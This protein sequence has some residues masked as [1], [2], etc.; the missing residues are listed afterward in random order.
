MHVG[1]LFSLVNAFQYLQVLVID[2]IG[3]YFTDIKSFTFNGVQ[4]SETTLKS[5]DSKW[6]IL[7]LE[8]LKQKKETFNIVYI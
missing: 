2:S 1:I 7:N 4:K 5:L 3:T 8:I 6:Q